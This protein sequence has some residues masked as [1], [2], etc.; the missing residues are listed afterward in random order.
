MKTGV[1]KWFNNEKGFGF[2]S[3]EGEGDVFVHFSAITGDR[4]KTLEE[5]QSVEFEVVDGAKGPQAA[6]VVRL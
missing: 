5:G 6:N 3:V 1:V 4:Y 2:I